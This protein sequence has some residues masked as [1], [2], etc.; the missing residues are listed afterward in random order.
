MIRNLALDR[1][2]DNDRVVINGKQITVPP[3]NLSAHRRYRFSA[4]FES[5]KRD[6]DFFCF[7]GTSAGLKV[8]VECPE[9]VR[10][11]L[12]PKEEWSNGNHF[13]Y[14]RLW[15][16][17]EALVIQWSKEKEKEA[18]GGGGT[19]GTKAPAGQASENKQLEVKPSENKLATDAASAPRGAADAGAK[20]T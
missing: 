18:K 13:F 10:V 19:A 2:D 6:S 12:E 17:N 7:Y 1:K 20:K 8:I 11:T 14:T 3:H 5:K 15:E 9:N 16:E 4:K